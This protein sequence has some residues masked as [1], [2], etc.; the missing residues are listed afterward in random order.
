MNKKVLLA[1][2]N[3]TLFDKSVVRQIIINF[4]YDAKTA[5]YKFSLTSVYF[6]KLN[7]N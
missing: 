2:N 4:F 5:Y 3:F 6:L 7:E 1:K